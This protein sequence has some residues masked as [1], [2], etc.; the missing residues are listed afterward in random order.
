MSEQRPAFA[1]KIPPGT[2]VRYDAGKFETR[3]TQEGAP[4]Y[5]VE[6][7]LALPW[8]YTKVGTTV[9]DLEAQGGV[10]WTALGCGAWAV[11][12]CGT[13]VLFDGETKPTWIRSSLLT[14]IGFAPAETA[15]PE[16]FSA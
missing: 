15:Q 6:G 7:W 4:F 8:A 11:P 5:L 2:R 1:D 12:E 16:L 14:V 10:D 9:S 3:G 13:G